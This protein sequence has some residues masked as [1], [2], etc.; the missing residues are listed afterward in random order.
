MGASNLDAMQLAGA[1]E[2][3]RKGGLPAWQVLQP[4]YNLYHRPRLKARC[5]ISA[6]AAI[7]GGDLLQPGLRVLK[8]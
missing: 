4:E 6:S 5:A 3:A 2:V 8:R 7:S 1:L